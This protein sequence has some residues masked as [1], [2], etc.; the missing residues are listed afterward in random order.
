[1]NFGTARGVWAAM[2]AYLL[3]G[4]LPAYWK[5]LKAVPA[6]QILC[7]RILW[8]ALF[9]TGLVV[10]RGEWK[11]F[12]E[13][14][15]NRRT[16]LYYTAAAVLL[17]TNWFTYIWAVNAN[18]IVETSLGYFIN[19][20]VN[21]LLALLVLKER[22]DRMQWIAVGCAIAG[23]GYLTW[24][25]GHVP[26]VALTLALSFGSY[27]LIKKIAPLGALYGLTLETAVLVLPALVCL[28]ALPAGLGAT[29]ASVGAHG[30]GTTA[31]LVGTGI[32][33][34]FPLLLFAYAARATSLSTLGILQYSS[35]TCGLLIG[36]LVYHEPFTTSRLIGFGIIW[37]GLAVYTIDLTRR[38]ARKGGG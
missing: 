27:A 19:P 29:T 5:A 15:W 13:A 32:V 36:V 25:Y 3:W 4:V 9:V 10:G 22:L 35:P 31:L 34:A 20:L 6:G 8:S 14:A 38:L 28:F 11:A 33:T 2:G 23:V 7:H 26:L 24:D 37:V 21:I 30:A 1:M 16:V 17:S 12:R 18:R